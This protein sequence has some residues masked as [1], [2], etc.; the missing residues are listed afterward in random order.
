MTAPR[1][2]SRW[3]ALRV[4]PGSRVTPGT[5]DAL[6]L[7][8]R[9]LEITDDAGKVRHMT[10]N[11]LLLRLASDD[12]ARLEPDL[13]RIEGNPGE[14]LCEH[15]EAIEHV[16]FPVGGLL[17]SVVTLR[18]G[19]VAEAATIGRDGA[20]GLETLVGESCSPCRIVQQVSGE[21]LRL[22]VQ[23]LRAAMEASPTARS[24]FGHYY[25][26]LA[27]QYAQN[28]ACNL[29]HKIEERLCRWL[30]STADRVGREAFPVTQEFLAEMLG[31]SRQSVSLT[32]SQLQQSG[33]IAY[34]RGNLRITDRAGLERTACECYR[35]TKETYERLM[36]A[37]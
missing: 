22:P 4:F 25:L 8:D 11:K 31:V 10:G 19:A 12:R 37:A 28:A 30:L 15:A 35:T 1:Q 24:V 17:S 6:R 20:A 5:A 26:S 2:K 9:E 33:L 3:Q 13:R 34:R 27:Q 36:Q 14:V 21:L 16:Y 29:H 23:T 7:R 32:A 18:D